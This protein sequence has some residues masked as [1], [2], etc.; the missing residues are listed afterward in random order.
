MIPQAFIEDIQTRTDIAEVIASYIPLKKMGRNFKGLCPFHG[1]KTPSFMVSPQKQIF[2]CF[3]CGEGG[4]VIQFLMLYEK[5]T[6]P[7]AIEILAQ[8]LGVA[9][10]YQRQEQ[11]R[12][13]PA[14]YDAVQEASCFFH[15]NLLE[16]KEGKFPLEYLYKRGIDIETIKKFRLGY[17]LGRNTLIDT[18]RKKNFS[19]EALEKASLAVAK[20]PGGYRDV[21]NDRIMFPIFDA[22][23]K[24]IGFGGRIWKNLPDAPKYINSLEGPLYSKRDHL[25]GLNFAKDDVGKSDAVIVVEG[26]LDMIVPFSKGIHNIVASLGTALTV[27]QI[28][29]IRRYTSNVVLLF[30]SDKAGELATLR[31]LDLVLENDINVAIVSL[32][33]GHDPDTL[34]RELG[35]DAFTQLLDKKTDFFEYKIAVFKRMYDI[36]TIEGKTKIA[37]EMLTTIAKLKSEIERYEYI[38]KLSLY[39]D[40]KEEVMLAEFRKVAVSATAANTR[41]EYR[42]AAPQPQERLSVTERVLLKFMFTN[43][44]ALAVIKRNVKESDFSSNIARKAAA[45]FFKQYAA[46]QEYSAQSVLGTI[47]D[48]EVCS[49]VSQILMDEEIPLD[50]E[51]FKSSLAKVLTRRVKTIKERMKT[52]IK[53]A[54]KNGDRERIRVLVNQYSRINSEGQDE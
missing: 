22:R 51:L 43:H 24:V 36:G 9:I 8:R 33:K 31:A 18:L 34:V 28:R 21:F 7:E 23:S 29:L 30:D 13:K 53:E 54:E 2:H 49:F 35:K 32:P 41:S 46:G 15:K 37:Q 6:F 27:E 19:L 20:G 17:A 3:G 5:V 39:L 10:P 4:G 16:T 48:K 47:A 38:K 40:I 50:K 52:E 11:N 14:L 26:Y 42:Q 12:M 45:Y 25:Y 44:K 1:E